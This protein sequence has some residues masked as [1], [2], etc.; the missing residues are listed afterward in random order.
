MALLAALIIIESGPGLGDFVF[1]GSIVTGAW[2]VGV[3]VRGRS[4]ENAA[5]VERAAVLEH[6]RE[7]LVA[8]ALAEERAHIAREP[9]DVIAHSVSVVVVQTAAV[10]RRLQGDRPDDAA[11]LETIERTA[12]QA[13]QEMRR[14]LG[15]LLARES[16]LGLTRARS[17]RPPGAACTDAG[18][19]SASRL[20]RGG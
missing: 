20:S 7:A 12:R 19:G 17:R 16:S 5:L 1:V 3:L 9:H 14:L 4:Q 6:D 10:R 8:K 18:V 15:V 11:Q 2:V 13:M